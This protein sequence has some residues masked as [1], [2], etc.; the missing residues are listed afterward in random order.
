V[1][2]LLDLGS[3]LFSAPRQ[4]FSEAYVKWDQA[5]ELALKEDDFFGQARAL[6]NMGCALRSLSQYEKALA[7]QKQAWVMSLRYVEERFKMDSSSNWLSLVLRTLDLDDL[8]SL[9]TAVLA[10]DVEYVH[11]NDSENGGINGTGH[12]SSSTT[13]D[14]LSNFYNKS[15]L[16]RSSSVRS[17]RS[18]ST[19]SNAGLD[20][21]FGP[22]IVVW[23]M[24]L[25]TNLG[26]AHICMGEIEE[27]ISWHA[28]CLQL[29][30][31]VLEEY[32]LPTAFQLSIAEL[33]GTSTAGL[34][35]YGQ[36]QKAAAKHDKIKL[37]FL[38]QQTLLAQARSLTSI[39]VCCQHMGL[40]DNALQC[41]TH[42]AA[43]LN[44]YSAKAIAFGNKNPST[45]AN[46][47]SASPSN[48]T[49]PTKQSQ[50]PTPTAAGAA[51]PQSPAVSVTSS[52]PATS[53]AV[54]PPP[55][56]PPPN[57]ASQRKTSV[58]AW[59]AL[60]VE[61][62]Q[63]AI[64]AN[65]ATSYHSKGRLPSALERLEKA[66]RIYGSA[67]DVIG[68]ARSVASI[69]AIKIDVGRV[70]GALHWV[71][72]ME[73]QAVGSGEVTECM[74]YWGPPR[75]SSLNANSQE[76]DESASISAG[77]AWVLEGIQGMLNMMA[78]L[79]EKDD[80]L[81]VLCCV[82]NIGKFLLVEHTQLRVSG[83]ELS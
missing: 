21:A 40:D 37:S 42:A 23:F 62:Y 22:P 57:L 55:S 53:A 81:S 44:F 47:A 28:K 66:A 71:R 32:P 49:S 52:S 50:P 7:Y 69:N 3:S 30:E 76:W 29:A 75:L 33:S 5:H 11:L 34:T 25:T 56:G 80:L 26:N 19:T 43:I 72:N 77:S 41:H 16:Q 1:N 17:A 31:N 61:L 2:E 14:H 70:L 48:V 79:K 68:T 65:L 78:I 9:S 59:D 18:V 8:D 83:V 24:Q 15:R 54:P 12:G 39:G 10:A 27:A 6:S 45:Q 58:Q 51:L 82:L 73:S 63:A 67:H 38:H 4:N 60:Q 35:V 46:V 20:V 36:P 13:S 74:R 64:F